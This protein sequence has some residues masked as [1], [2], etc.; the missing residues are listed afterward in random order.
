MIRKDEGGASLCDMR[1]KTEKWFSSS[2]RMVYLGRCTCAQRKDAE[3][4]EWRRRGRGD[5]LGGACMPLRAA[6]EKNLS[7]I[8]TNHLLCA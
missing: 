7:A 8:L 3:K 6:G 1:C 5:G 2:A 4:P